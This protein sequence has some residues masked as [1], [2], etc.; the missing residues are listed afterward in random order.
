MVRVSDLIR[1][2]TSL[3]VVPI[4]ETLRHAKKIARQVGIVRVTDTTYLDRIGMP[5]YVSIRPNAMIYSLCVSSGKGMRHEEAEIGAYMEGIEL[6]FAEPHTAKL[7]IFPGRVRGV[8]DG[9]ERERAIFDFCPAYNKGV[10]LDAPIDCVEADDLRTGDKRVVP[11]ENVLFPVA[12]P[13]CGGELFFGSDT[14]GL[15]SGNS[16]DEATVHGITEII[17]RDVTTF[18]N[19]RNTS[20]LIYTPVMRHL[21]T[22]RT[23]S[24]RPFADELPKEVSDFIIRLDEQGFDLWIRSLPNELGLPVISAVL[25]ERGVLEAVHLGYGCHLSRSIALVRAIS[26]AVQGRLSVIHGGRD[27]LYQIFERQTRLSKEQKAKSFAER[28]EKNSTEKLGV[29]NFGEVPDLIDQAPDVQSALALLLERL[30]A[31]GFRFALR[32]PITPP[33]M[34]IQVVRVLIPGMEMFCH[35]VERMGPRLAKV[36]AAERDLRER[37]KD[38]AR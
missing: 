32:V 14:N 4:A 27:D 19:V 30:A 38:Q 12:H 21:K 28:S 24:G 8:L 18:N 15:C 20:Q 1:Y 11:A 2:N 36:Q 3:R 7:K 29:V 6:G 9:A 31:H 33:D 34:P 5:V 23:V 25:V 13:L 16:I 37:A 22:D 26:E 35:G 17:E 10:N